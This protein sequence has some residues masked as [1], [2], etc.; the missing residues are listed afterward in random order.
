MAAGKNAVSSILESAGWATTDADS[1]VHNAITAAEPQI[2]AEFAEEAQKAGI[3][4]TDS[5]GRLNRRALGSLIFPNPSLLARQESLVYPALN[6]LTEEFINAHKNQNIALNATVLFKVPALMK[7]CSAVLFVT[8]PLYIRFFRAR[9]R[10]GMKVNHILQ[11]FQ[12]QR[13][14]YREYV[15]TGIPVIKIS[16][17]GSLQTLKHKILFELSHIG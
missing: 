7:K 11:R 15:K 17:S 13:T 4:L 6:T 10:D 9:K 14:L 16:N 1:L 12:A 3:T 5:D 8:A 2:I